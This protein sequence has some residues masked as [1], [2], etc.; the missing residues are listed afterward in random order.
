MGEQWRTDGEQSDPQLFTLYL[1]V[2]LI[3]LFKVNSGE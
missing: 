3:F 2:L 1:T